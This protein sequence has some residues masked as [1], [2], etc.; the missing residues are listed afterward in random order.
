MLTVYVCLEY[1][2]LVYILIAYD[3]YLKLTFAKRC[4]CQDWHLIS[5][6]D[7]GMHILSTSISNRA[8]CSL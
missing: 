1:S 2:F 6:K 3:Y 7:K 4:L 8:D 5:L